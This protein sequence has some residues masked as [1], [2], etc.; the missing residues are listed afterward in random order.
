MLKKLSVAEVEHI[1]EMAKAARDARDQ[2]LEMVHEEALGEPKPVRGEHN[3][4]AGLGLDPLP[5]NHPVRTALREAITALPSS[6]RWEL[7]ALMWVG[8]GDYASKDIKRAVVNASA[9]QD[10]IT[11]GALMDQS[12]LHELLM[13]GLYELKLL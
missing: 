3:P 9:V 6:A 7:R 12:D 1:A 4:A 5:P 13:K 11:I 2:M 10:D 8:R